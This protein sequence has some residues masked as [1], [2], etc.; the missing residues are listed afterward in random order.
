MV[1]C[2]GRNIKTS[3]LN[4]FKIPD[5]VIKPRHFYS[6]S[7]ILM[8]EAKLY[9]KNIIKVEGRLDYRLWLKPFFSSLVDTLQNWKNLSKHRSNYWWPHMLYAQHFQLA[10]TYIILSVAESVDR[11]IVSTLQIILQSI[12]R[13][14]G[15][16]TFPNRQGCRLWDEHTCTLWCRNVFT[17][18]SNCSKAPHCTALVVD[19]HS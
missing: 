7:F 11:Y 9:I 2:M 14:Y 16:I 12:A 1:T 6:G 5:S 18:L 13:C 19:K 4:V 17:S 10:K 15:A 3:T 8:K